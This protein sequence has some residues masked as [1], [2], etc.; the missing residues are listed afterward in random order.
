MVEFSFRN[1]DCGNG[2][3]LYL[4]DRAEFNAATLKFETLEFQIK[5]RFAFEGEI[6]SPAR[7]KPNG[8]LLSDDGCFFFPG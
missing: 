2:F 3:R 8:L 4:F 1:E 5:I 6:N 7:I